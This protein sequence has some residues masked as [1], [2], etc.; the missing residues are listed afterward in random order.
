MNINQTRCHKLWI[1]SFALILLLVLSTGYFSQNRLSITTSPSTAA[2]GTEILWDKWGVPHIFAK[3]NKALFHAFGYA[4][5]QSHGDLILR[6]YGQ[7][8]GRAAEYWGQQYLESDRWIHINS[9]TRRAPEW[10]QA[11]SASFRSYLDAFAEGINTY[12]REH[13]NKI[14]DEV[15][16]VLPVSGVDVIAHAHRVI[17]FVFVAG[18][19]VISG[20]VRQ[21]ESQAGSNT[22]AIAP[23]R[24]ASKRAM[25]LANPHLPWSD[26]FLFY[27]AQLTAPGI[28]AYGATLVG[29]PVHGIAFNDHLGWSHTV[30]THDGDDLFELTLAE[31][32][33]RWDGKVRP[34]ETEEQVI[35]VK[36]KD[37]SMRDEK[38]VVR[39][40]V[41][42]PVVADKGS[43]AIALRV[44]ALNQPGM[45]EQ[46]WDMARAKNLKEF[47]TI[48]KR[49]Q[50]PM[51]TVMYA[52]RDGHI[53]HFF[54][55]RTPVRPHGDYNWE[56]I[57]SGD[58]S[59][60]MW[61]KTHVY[62]ELPRVID[63]PSGWLQ[64]AN[65]PPWTTTF[66]P[67]LDAN[68]FPKYM[69]PR[70]MHFRAQR[71][72]RMLDE[73]RSITFEEMIKY[74]H[75]TRM[76][77]ADHILDDLI[78]AARKSDSEK[79]KR[80][81]E[82][83]AAWDRCADAESRGAALFQFFTR[84][85]N[86]RAG[87]AD[88]F[89]VKWSESDPRNTPRGVADPVMAIAALE[90]AADQVGSAFG[91]IDVPWGKVA[92]LLQEQVDLPANGG[93]GELGIFRVVGFA[94][95]K[96]K[97]FRAVGGDS[98]VAAIEFSNP[99]R[100]MVLIGYGNA[101]QPGSPHLIDQLPLFSRKELRPA[102]RKREEIMKNLEDRKVF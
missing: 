67:A 102:W 86:N 51:F 97:I 14:A 87:K 44:V 65:D 29:F 32:G 45:L 72:A 99:V 78:V 79:A 75:S 11:Q 37:G 90:A 74:K 93:P 8:R 69:A 68:K 98:Y 33:Y 34:F 59:A 16:V 10:Y 20:A 40:S 94:A 1:S 3:D 63:P 41:H 73:D 30:N 36:Q 77:L 62:E 17:H 39:R 66:P 100:A 96:D 56:G 83:L 88:P 15:E 47:E 23:K 101:S 89:A 95:D 55:G 57:V 27:E 18:P 80:A 53:M 13:A 42:G 5:A 91:A 12:A 52:D 9:I 76:E 6:L 7:A 2:P 25:L 50:L 31:G 35:K 64:N 58:T 21:L 61:T 82:V 38:L 84:E 92:R 81:V 54:G 26:L 19:Q 4:Q 71:S 46:W 60:T 49:L 28:D 24:S 48:L 70:F 22:W 85:L 43:K